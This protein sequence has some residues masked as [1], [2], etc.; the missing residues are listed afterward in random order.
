MRLAGKFCLIRHPPYLL[1]RIF[2]LFIFGAIAFLLVPALGAY[3]IEPQKQRTWHFG[4]GLDL[5]DEFVF[6]ICDYALIIPQSPDHCYTITMRFLALVPTHEGK[7]WIVAAHVDHEPRTVDMIFQISANSFRIRTD[8]LNVSY[9]DSVERTVGWIRQFSN[10]N[11]PQA[12][13]VGRSWGAIPG[14]TNNP[15]KMM[16]NK[17]DSDEFENKVYLLGYSLIRNSQIQ[18]SDG[19]PFPLKATIYRPVSTHQD[20]PLSFEFHMVSYQNLDSKE[21]HPTSS[22]SK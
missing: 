18:I 7:V 13:V 20:V 6:H 10:E 15:I 12:L 17:I 21:C 9:A 16:V 2:C 14:D 5:G 19:L 8:G 4:Q 3:S 22:I 1:M 11:K